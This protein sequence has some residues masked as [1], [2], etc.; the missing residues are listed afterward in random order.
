[1]E[2]LMLLNENQNFGKL[3]SAAMSL[4]AFQ[5]LRDSPDEVHPD[6]N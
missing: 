3:E 1:M 6:F 5:Y 4:S 2:N